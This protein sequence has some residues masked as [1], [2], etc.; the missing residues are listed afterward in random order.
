MV[1]GWTGGW[2]IS[3]L[4]HTHTHKDFRDEDYTPVCQT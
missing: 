3:N 1:K 2:N 4:Q